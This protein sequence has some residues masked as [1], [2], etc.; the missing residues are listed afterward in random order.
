MRKVYITTKDNPHDP[1]KDFL[2]WFIYDV[3]N[4]YN[5]CDLLASRSM[6]S[7]SL[8]E[9]ENTNAIEYAIDQIIADDML[10]IYKKVVK[11]S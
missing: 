6:T 7:N 5:T 3:T 11:E 1:Q 4:G 2:S 10:N 9:S 8:T